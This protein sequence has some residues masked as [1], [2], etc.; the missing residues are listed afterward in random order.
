VSQQLENLLDV[1]H[2]GGMK[3]TTAHEHHGGGMKQTTAHE[4][5][6]GGMKQ[7]TAQDLVL[8]PSLF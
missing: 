3:Q 5:H 7:T 1:H 6:G 2:G 8:V 4:H